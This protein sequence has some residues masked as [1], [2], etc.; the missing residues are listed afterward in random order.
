MTAAEF[1]ALHKFYVKNCVFKMSQEFTTEVRIDISHKLDFLLKCLWLLTCW[2]E[3][4]K[5]A[6]Y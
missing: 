2:W 5:V 4:S 6:F 1:F 3:T